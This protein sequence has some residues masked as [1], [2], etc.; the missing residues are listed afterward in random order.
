MSKINKKIKNIKEE[1]FSFVY[2]DDGS[3]FEND[4]ELYSIADVVGYVAN[5]YG[6]NIEIECIGGFDSPGYDVCC[7]A[8]A[9]I[10][11]GELYFDGLQQ[12][13]Y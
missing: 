4:L 13:R 10:I 3:I 6:V 1:I 5:K 8:W 11:D 9:G 12:E 2:E 7:Y